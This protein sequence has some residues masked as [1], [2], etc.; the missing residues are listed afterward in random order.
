MR[1]TRPTV[2]AGMSES[3]WSFFLHEWARYTRLTGIRDEILRD[4]LWS[5]MEDNLRQLAFSEGF[6]ANTEPELIAKI[7]SDHTTSLSACRGLASDGAAG[8]R[9][10][11]GVH[12]QGQG[13]SQQL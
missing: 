10:Y 13:H 11:Q 3:E 7:S 9:V 6:V 8:E 1:P 2:I 12:R 5:C 4:E